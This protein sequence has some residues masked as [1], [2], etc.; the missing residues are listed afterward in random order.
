M[1]IMDENESYADTLGSCGSGPPDPYLCSLASQYASVTDWYAVE[2]PSQPN[3][4]DIVSGSDQG[5]HEDNCVGAGAYSAEDLGAELSQAGIPWT[6]YM[7]SM[8]SPCFTGISSG[9]DGSGEY[10]LRHDP[11]VLFQNNLSGSCHILPYPGEASMVSALDGTAAPD[12]VWITPNLCDDM[13]DDCGPGNVQQGDAWL[14]TNLPTVVSSS[15]FQ[16]NGTVIIT[17]DEGADDSGCCGD[18]A[19]GQV[20]MVVISANAEGRGD[21]SLNG[22]HFGSLRTI[23]EAFG[24]PL[25][26]AA[27]DV[28]NGDLGQLFG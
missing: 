16:D 26:G 14:E 13:H 15:W 6:V 9:D 1:V 12:F 8:P 17:A 18:A 20:P 3:Y 2:H 22:N 10:V 7:E 24:L 19:G 25:L 27:S 28:A 21:I 4:T 11:F 23:E 5:C